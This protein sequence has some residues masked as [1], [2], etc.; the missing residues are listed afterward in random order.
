MAIVEKKEKHRIIK[1]VVKDETVAIYYTEDD[2]QLRVL[3]IPID[4]I[5]LTYNT[6]II[7]TVYREHDTKIERQIVRKTIY[8][9]EDNLVFGQ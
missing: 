9:T 2:I 5:K 4:E 6:N 7:E 8:I 1:G 3:Y